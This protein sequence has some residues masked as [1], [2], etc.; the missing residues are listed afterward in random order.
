MLIYGWSII[1]K[2]FYEVGEIIIF[3]NTLVLKPLEYS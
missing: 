3:G 2:F 1:P